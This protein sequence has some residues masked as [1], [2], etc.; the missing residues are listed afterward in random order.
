MKHGAGK[1]SSPLDDI[2]PEKWTNQFTTEL[3]ELLWAL[4]ATV[5][6]YPEQAKLLDAVT[7]G[8]CFQAAELPEVPAFMRKAPTTPPPDGGLFAMDKGE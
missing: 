3:L 2:R 4:E 1:K 6:S 7:K 8:D 5:E